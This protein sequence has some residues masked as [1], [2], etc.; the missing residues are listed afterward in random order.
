MPI[1]DAELLTLKPK[2][3]SYKVFIGKQAYLLVTPD[4]KKYWRLKYRLND[5]ES[6]NA[7]GVFPKISVRE[8]Q[9]ARESAIALIRQG[10][11]PS[12][13]RREA[14]LKPTFPDPLFRLELAKT[15]ALIIE[16][17]TTTLALSLPQ[18]K[19]LAAF[20][21]VNNEKEDDSR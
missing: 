2:A 8:A 5:E 16:T 21:G 17:D 4:G 13:A 7:L 1:T 18:T 20:L 15:G 9:A 10:I 14:R 6:I 3:R 12:V 11:N 19:A